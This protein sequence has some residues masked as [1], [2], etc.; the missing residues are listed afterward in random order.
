MGPVS[1]VL[2][3]SFSIPAGGV[4]ATNG[5][6]QVTLAAVDATGRAATNAVSIYPVAAATPAVWSSYYPFTSGAQDAS[7]RFNGTLRNG[8]SIVSDL[9]R[10]NVLGLQP[11]TSQYVSL[12][13]GAGAAQTVSGWVK[14]NG[15]NPWQRIF[16]FGQN[17]GDYFFLT[18]SDGAGLP[19]CAIT[20]QSAVYVQALE[21]PVAMPVG[22]WTHVA[23]AMDGREGI[24]YLNGSAVAVNNSV[25][26]LPSDLAP[27]NC[28]FG[29]SQFPAD[30]TFNGRLSAMRLN[31]ATV[32]LARIIAPLPAITQP[33][34]GSLFA[35]GSPLNFAG[36]ATDY[37]GVPLSTNA[38]AWAGEFHSNSVAYASFGP[39]MGVTNGAYL[40]P[41][42]AAIITNIFYRVN[43]VVTDTNGYQSAAS[44][45]V[46]PQTSQL[47]FDT[48]PPG[49]QLTLDGQALATP[50]SLAAVDGMNHSVVAPSP[51][52][53]S[54]T[55]YQFV[56]WSDGGSAAH[57]LAVPDTNANFTA[58][59]LQPVL[60]A[61]ATAGGLSLS[62]P[63][64]AGAMNLY[65]TT[66]LAPPIAWSPVAITQAIANGWLTVQLP[67]TNGNVFYHLQL[68]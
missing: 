51:Q 25:N 52:A 20:P 9:V 57:T 8:A 22:Q 16:D 50:A 59:Y 11:L 49:L 54:G 63:Q 4:A 37:S 32:P 36:T 60:G 43:L 64:W 38:F 45:D 27:T 61:G 34:G 56:V 23:V 24:L 13:A 7:N 15:G 19:Q 14:W 62:W 44:A 66:N 65:S 33:A 28:N 6:Y 30:P 58:S 40:V 41:A 17:I 12:P 68:P 2:A 39:L 10:G 46:G 48:V 1:G 26:L 53:Q 3:S 5:F 35:G 42:N 67:A 47:T 21:S 31:S 18:T 55:N 29:K